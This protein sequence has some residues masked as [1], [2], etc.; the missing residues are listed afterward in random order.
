[1]RFAAAL[2]L[3]LSAAHGQFRSTVPLVVAPTT[4]R[5]SKGHFVDGLTESDLVLY[6]NN[7]PQRIQLDWEVYPISLV[8]AVQVSANSEAVIDKLGRTGILFSEL[9][10]AHKGETAL[11]SFAS[12][13]FH[14]QEFTTDPD[15]LTRAIRKLRVR[16][17]DA[18][19]LDGMMEALHM[20]DDRA[21]NR[22][23]IILM[24]SEK[25][26]RTSESKLTDVVKEVQRQNAL[27]Y[28]LTYS[29]LLTPFTAKMKTVDGKP[30][31][32]TAQPLDPLSSLIVLFSEL[33]HLKQPDISD[34][35]PKVT[36]ARTMNFLKRSALEE[37][38]QAIGEEV[39]RQYIISYQ[40]PA[41]SPGKFHQI[42]IEAA[43]REGLRIKTRA[44]YW[45]PE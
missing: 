23:R 45:T 29:P 39:H 4:V 28:W 18:A 32:P 20:L 8:V 7:V 34:L 31:P 43:E 27:I 3:T 2:L 19:P 40:P 38:I 33:G 41:A 36:G 37:A 6:D 12:R 25:R 16:K 5:D 14:E 35:F 30:L 21:P 1:M 10:A 26:D 13:V 42:R 24:I 22:R 11:V 44:G 17:G 9:V 15:E